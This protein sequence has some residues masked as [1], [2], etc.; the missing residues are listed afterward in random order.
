M[1]KE[2]K[3]YKIKLILDGVLLEEREKDILLTLPLKNDWKISRNQESRKSAST[4]TRRKSSGAKM[5]RKCNKRR[6]ASN[7]K[8]TTR[9]KKRGSIQSFC[10]RWLHRKSWNRFEGRRRRGRRDIKKSARLSIFLYWMTRLKWLMK[11]QQ[12]WKQKLLL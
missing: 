8:L 1:K 2:N 4:I 6:R 9:Q 3:K 10:R 7:K 11:K 5:K 12:N